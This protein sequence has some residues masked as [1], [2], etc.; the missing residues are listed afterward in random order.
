METI[1]IYF[2]KMSKEYGQYVI[3]NTIVT[4]KM[5]T[6]KPANLCQSPSQDHIG[7]RLRLQTFTLRTSAFSNFDLRMSY[8]KLLNASSDLGCLKKLEIYSYIKM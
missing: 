1:A 5:S 6:N 8:P 4:V 3:L 7:L 2:T